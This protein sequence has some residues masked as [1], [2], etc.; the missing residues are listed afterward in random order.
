MP[1]RF[2]SVWLPRVVAGFLMGA[3]V[4]MIA[5]YVVEVLQQIGGGDQP[6]DVLSFAEWRVHLGY[7]LDLSSWHRAR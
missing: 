2:R 4:F 7:A 3:M 6:T 1:P 5:G